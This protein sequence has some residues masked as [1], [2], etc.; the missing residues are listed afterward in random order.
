V[1]SE[2]RSAEVIN[3]LYQTV[4]KGAELR[5]YSPPEAAVQYGD[6]ADRIVET[7]KERGSDLIV[8]GIRNAAG[9]LGTAAHLELA[10][11]HK[12]VARCAANEPARTGR[13]RETEMICV[14]RAILRPERARQV[15][16]I[17][18]KPSPN[19]ICDACADTVCG[20]ARQ[21][22][23]RREELLYEVLGSTTNVPGKET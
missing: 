3:R 9:H 21:E 14:E 15:C 20:R 6:P 19:T 8:L 4:P 13:R 23:T 17:C 11:A 2:N 1:S 7:A 16:N 22:E 10:T 12:V 18:G 5:L